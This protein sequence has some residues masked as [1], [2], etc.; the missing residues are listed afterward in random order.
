[1]KTYATLITII[2]YCGLVTERR[3][4]RH[5]DVYKKFSFNRIEKIFLK[6]I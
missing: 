5:E 4:N 6:L 2:N 3:N 1:M